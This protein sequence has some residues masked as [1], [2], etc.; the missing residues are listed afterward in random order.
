[1]APELIV[2][3][4]YGPKVDIWSLGIMVIEMLEGEPPYLDLSCAKAL[5]MITTIGVPP[6][7]NYDTFSIEL[8]DFLKR[9]LERDQ[10]LRSS[11]IELLQV[12]LFYI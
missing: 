4:D 2:G 3:D 10:N 7:K 12:S 9:C 5:Q 1:M 6:P 8:K 11:A